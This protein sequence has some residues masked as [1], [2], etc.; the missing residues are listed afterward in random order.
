MTVRMLPRAPRRP[1]TRHDDFPVVGYQY[2]RANPQH[3]AGSNPANLYP[4]LLLEEGKRDRHGD[5]SSLM[6]LGGK[7]WPRR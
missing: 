4:L 6:S 7:R 5:S 3:T 2:D 1:V